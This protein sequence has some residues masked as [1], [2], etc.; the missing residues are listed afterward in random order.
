M[1]VLKLKYFCVRSYW[2][3]SKLYLK[4]IILLVHIEKNN[5]FYYLWKDKWLIFL[6][7]SI[8][9]SLCLYQIPIQ[10]LQIS[11]MKTSNVFIV[12]SLISMHNAF[13]FLAHT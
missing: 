7:A 11:V 9:S 10:H 5:F 3:S 6:T 12:L 2:N 8:L 13:I 1:P 4:W